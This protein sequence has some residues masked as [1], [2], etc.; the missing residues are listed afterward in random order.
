MK[1]GAGFDGGP[2][3]NAILD[4]VAVYE[5]PLSEEQIGRAMQGADP[6]SSDPTSAA[7]CLLYTSCNSRKRRLHSDVGS[8]R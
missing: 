4:D 1:I 2:F 3:L 5:T 6:F 8:R 7:P